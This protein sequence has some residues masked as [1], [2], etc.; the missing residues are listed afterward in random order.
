MRDTERACRKALDGGLNTQAASCSSSLHALPVP[1]LKSIPT[2]GVQDLD[3]ISTRSSA[4]PAAAPSV[5]LSNMHH[6]CAR[7]TSETI[8]RAS[9]A[10]YAGSY[11]EKYIR[12]EP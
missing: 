7:S 5:V 10:R 2:G 8:C 12:G 11:E 9:D 3:S 6:V 1:L 4:F